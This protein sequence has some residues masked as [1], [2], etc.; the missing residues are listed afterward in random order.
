MYYAQY[1]LYGTA[2][3]FGFANAWQV[4]SFDTKSAA[5][6]HPVPDDGPAFLRAAGF[7]ET[8]P[9]P[10]EW[11]HPVSPLGDVIARI[12]SAP[13]AALR[14]EVSAD[15]MGRRFAS[16]VAEGPA[17]ICAAVEWAAAGLH[18]AR[19]R[20]RARIRAHNSDLELDAE[21]GKLGYPELSAAHA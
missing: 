13:G 2:T 20:I 16:R 10:G 15:Y 9:G 1:N 6:V 21:L 19:C 8:G 5:G 11:V 3:D 17:A 4:A 14:V 12:V 7:A 18:Q